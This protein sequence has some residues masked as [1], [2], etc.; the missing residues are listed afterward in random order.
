MAQTADVHVDRFLVPVP[1]DD[2]EEDEL[3]LWQ[4]TSVTTSLG[5]LEVDSPQVLPL[6]LLPFIL[7]NRSVCMSIGSPRCCDI[8]TVV[9]HDYSLFCCVIRYFMDAA[10]ILAP[11][12]WC[13]V[14]LSS[15]P[16]S[17]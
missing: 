11:P 9:P 12:Q 13:L 5:Q 3:L 16:S 8:H 7:R 14:Q 15:L 10:A 2:D 4:L 1:T 6:S 17:L